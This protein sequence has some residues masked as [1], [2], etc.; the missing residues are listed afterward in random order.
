[1][2]TLNQAITLIQTLAKSHKQIRTFIVGAPAE[3][4]A[5]GEV[6]PVGCFLDFNTGVI[7]WKDLQ[8]FVTFEFWLVDLI[9]VSEDTRSNEVEVLSDLYSIAMD[10]YAMIADYAI[11]DGWTIAETSNVQF[12]REKL[13]DM[14]GAVHFTLDISIDFLKDTCQV[15]KN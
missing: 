14:F 8:A 11:Q 10:L 7:S 3:W 15:P 1:M 12:Q 13:E 9:N 5:S 4:L 6:L 2:T